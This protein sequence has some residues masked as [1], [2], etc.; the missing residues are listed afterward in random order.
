ALEYNEAKDAESSDEVKV[1]V[2]KE[3]SRRVTVKYGMQTKNA[4]VIQK[5]ITE[6]KLLEKLLMNAFQDT[7]GHY[8]GGFQFRLE[9]R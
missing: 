8:G 1:T 6:Y 9:F 2:G 5:V 4:K 3:L 7:E